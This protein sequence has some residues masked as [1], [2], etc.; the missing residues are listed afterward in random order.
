MP[1]KEINKLS[2]RREFVI[3][4]LQPGTNRREL[5]RRY[6]ISHKTGYKWFNRY[7][8]GGLEALHDLSRQP[9]Y[10]PNKTPLAVTSDILQLRDKHPAWGGRKIRTRLLVL[11]RTGVPAASTITEI[12][13]RHGRLDE[14]ESSKHKAFTR[15][16]YEEP[17][18]LWQMDFK[19]HFP[20]KGGR[21]HP[22]GVLDDHSRFALGLFACAN[23]QGV[24]VKGHLRE[25][26]R[27]YGLP[28][29]ILVDNG[30]P[31]GSDQEHVYTRLTVWMLRMRVRVIHGR[32]FHPQTQGK[33]ERFNRT[34][35]AELL[36]YEHFEDLGHCQRRFDC[37]RDIYNQERPHEALGMAVPASRY[38][39][40]QRKFPEE[41]PPIEYAPGDEVRKVQK[42]GWI[43]YRGQI[44]RICKAFTGYPVAL[45]NT[46]EDGLLNVVF[47][48][49]TIAKIDLCAHNIHE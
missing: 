28:D 8:K 37:W 42:G 26:F 1:W 23:E 35:Q 40:S 18:Q 3:Q 43:S 5:C 15:F 36:R 17:N 14:E 10:S 39:P 49:H 2:L 45:R 16:E 30:S 12:L 19:G 24:T 27:R 20:I 34:L 25:V 11:G 46:A 41:I 22:L 7:N 32:P 44:Y 4:A 13:R 9:K 29:C 21:C 33:E 48:N 38:R 31:W 47:C 6:E